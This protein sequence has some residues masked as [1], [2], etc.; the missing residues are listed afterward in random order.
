MSRI[1]D[2]LKYTEDHE[3]IKVTDGDA[4][5]GITDYA[6]DELGDI[7]YVELPEVGEEISKGDMLGVI[8]SVKTVSDLYAPISGTVKDVNEKLEGTPEVINEDPYKDGWIVVM[9]IT[10]EDELD[11]LLDPEEYEEM[12]E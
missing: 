12:L 10:H 6:Q 8:E 3:W 7:V 4:R 2:N 9:E 11:E 1:P 5:Y